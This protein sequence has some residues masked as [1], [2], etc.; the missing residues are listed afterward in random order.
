MLGKDLREEL[1]RNHLDEF[2]DNI[3]SLN[4]DMHE[5]K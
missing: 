5:L 3:K 4:K 2:I 1:I